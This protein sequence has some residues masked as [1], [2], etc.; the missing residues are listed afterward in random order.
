MSLAVGLPDIG[1]G[2]RLQ[3]NEEDKLVLRSRQPHN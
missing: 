3:I 1:S 2:L